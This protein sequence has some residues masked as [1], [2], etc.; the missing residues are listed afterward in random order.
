MKS[1]KTVLTAT[2]CSLSNTRHLHMI[3]S[4]L[5]FT[6][7]EKGGFGEIFP[8]V[9]IQ[10]VSKKVIELWSALARLLC[11]LQ[12]SFFHSWKSG[13]REAERAPKQ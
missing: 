9:I 5:S 10:S 8:E 3:M 12:K 4:H 2:N 6:G 13:R 1:S 11:N 7:A